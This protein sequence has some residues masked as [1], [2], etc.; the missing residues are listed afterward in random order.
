MI[1]KKKRSKFVVNVQK[2]SKTENERKDEMKIYCQNR[3]KSLIGKNNL[4]S[5]SIHNK[6]SIDYGTEIF[7]TA[8]IKTQNKTSDIKADNYMQQ[9]FLDLDQQN[10][11]DFQMKIERK[12]KIK[13]RMQDSEY[14]FIRNSCFNNFS[15][16]MKA[17]ACSDMKR[18]VRSL[19]KSIK[20]SGRNIDTL[21]N[22]C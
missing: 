21:I 13:H 4:I 6:Y 9:F 16:E 10:Y 11:D 22:S 2:K 8:N 17:Y 12:R 5:K 7:K 20:E 19:D 18:E 3:I 1:P 14:K 15:K